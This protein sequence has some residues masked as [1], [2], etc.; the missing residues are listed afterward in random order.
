MCRFLV[1]LMIVAFNFD[2]SS[3]PSFNCT[4]D[5]CFPSPGIA[6][7]QDA[8]AEISDPDKLILKLKFSPDEDEL[9]TAIVR[10]Y[11]V[12]DWIKVASVMRTRNARQCRERYKNYLDPDL[13][14]GSWTAQEDE[15]LETKHQEYGA[16]WN[17]IARFF[18]NRSDISLRNRWMVLA[19]HHAKE[20]A[21][22]EPV[23]QPL[24]APQL[25]L[26]V[27]LPITKDVPA[28]QT[29]LSEDSFEMFEVPQFSVGSSDN[30]FDAWFPF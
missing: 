6:A 2:G 5:V 26:P 12:K 13:R 14:R 1:N 11:G 9:L 19:R 18:V 24:P 15:L 27:V 3:E 7:R 20:P 28:R 29:R 25:P 30:F 23:R 17:K 21:A 10:E 4:M 8:Q 22:V 16:K